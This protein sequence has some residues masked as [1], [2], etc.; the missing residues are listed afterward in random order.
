MRNSELTYLIRNAV[1]RI[2]RTDVEDISYNAAVHATNVVNRNQSM[3]ARVA[4]SN[5]LLRP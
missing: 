3:D 5:S 1:T 2:P 4:N